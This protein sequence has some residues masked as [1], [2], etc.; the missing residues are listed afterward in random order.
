MDTE[1]LSRTITFVIFAVI[2]Y[3]VARKMALPPRLA[4]WFLWVFTFLMVG[5]IG[6]HT[7]M[8]DISGYFTIYL[9]NLLQGL[10]AG[11]LINFFI[12]Q[13]KLN[14]SNPNTSQPD[15]MKR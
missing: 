5:T 7:R 1:T 9:N 14:A 2:G 8:V 10:V 15:E 11:L 4:E 13:T 6:I 12:R 3:L